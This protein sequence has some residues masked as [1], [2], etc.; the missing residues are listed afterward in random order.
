MILGGLGGQ[1]FGSFILPLQ[2]DLGWPKGTISIARSLMQVE[3]ELLGPIEGSVPVIVPQEEDLL[4]T[5]RTSACVFNGHQDSEL[6][7]F[8]I[9]SPIPC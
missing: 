8:G 5:G 6:I 4:T 9:T 2:R 1:G 3:N 7:P